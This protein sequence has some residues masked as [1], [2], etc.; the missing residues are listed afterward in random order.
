LASE[1]ALVVRIAVFNGPNLNLLG[2]R[3]PDIYGTETLAAVERMVREHAAAMS[4]EIDWF[5]TNSEGRFVEL[6]QEAAGRVAGAVVNA[7]AFTHTSIAIR[8]A[9]LAVNIPFVEAHLSNIFAREEMR[10]RSLLADL[11]VG[12]VTGFGVGSYELALRGLLQ[13]LRRVES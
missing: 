3:E 11:A 13:H 2:Q 12:V 5:Q 4:V 10:R 1:S 8:D 9:L 6:I 7:A